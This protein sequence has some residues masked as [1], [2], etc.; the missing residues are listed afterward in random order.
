M[1]PGIALLELCGEVLCF[2]RRIWAHKISLFVPRT[3]EGDERTDSALSQSRNQGDVASGVGTGDDENAQMPPKVECCDQ[4]AIE[5]YHRGADLPEHCRTRRNKLFLS[6][7]TQPLTWVETNP[8]LRAPIADAMHQQHPIGD[9]R[10]KLR[11]M[12]TPHVTDVGIL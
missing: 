5:P 10:A 3:R 7:W 2:M 4:N 9:G 6:R 1:S 8:S 11:A 12:V